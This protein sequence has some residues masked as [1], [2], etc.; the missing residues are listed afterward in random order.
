[1]KSRNL[2]AFSVKSVLADGINSTK[3]EMK[4][5]RD[6]ILL[7]Q[8]GEDEFDF[9]LGAAKDFIQTRLNFIKQSVIS[10]LLFIVNCAIIITRGDCYDRKQTCRF[11]Y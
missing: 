6:E 1:M 5:L 3:C 2:K 7:M 4:S 10:L 9:I 8:G 11:I